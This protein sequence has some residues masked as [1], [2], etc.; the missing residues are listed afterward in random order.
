MSADKPSLWSAANDLQT[1]AYVVGNMRALFVA[2]KKLGGEDV[3]GLAR[4]G[5][6]IAEE[7]EDNFGHQA[8]QF[9][10]E[11][12]AQQERQGGDQ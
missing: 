2:I 10:I 6:G 7:W 1:A 8:D 11:H 5:Q 4:L 9:F 12:K 3:N